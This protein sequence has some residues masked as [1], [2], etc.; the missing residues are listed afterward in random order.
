MFAMKTT[1][2]IPD[3]LY[4]EF[5]AKTATN[6][7]KMRNAVISFI[8]AYNAGEWRRDGETT[9]T[10]PS[11]R[12]RSAKSKLPEWAGIAEP[13]ITKYPDNP[14]DSE[15]MRDDIIAARRAGLQ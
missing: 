14:L 3:T 7:E 8:V 11:A 15:I 9:A 2:D 5:K 13:F 4:R 10:G 1:L 6:G 12:R